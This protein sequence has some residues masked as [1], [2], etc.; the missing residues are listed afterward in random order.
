MYSTY[1]I[2]HIFIL[3]SIYF[4]VLLAK[5]LPRAAG[6]LELFSS[7]CQK[8]LAKFS[9]S[10]RNNKPHSGGGTQLGIQTLHFNTGNIFI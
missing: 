9:V 7:C 10:N 5:T 2:P 1:T 4:F 6:A 8:K 3:Y